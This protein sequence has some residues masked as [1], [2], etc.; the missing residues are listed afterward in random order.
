MNRL[1]ALWASLPHQVQAGFILFGTVA[2]TTLGKELQAL[3]FGTESFSRS[4]LQHDVGF[5]VA[6]GF[7]AVRAFYM[8]PSAPAEKANSLGAGK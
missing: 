7:I 8:V 3:I 1:K 5:A 2:L 6:A 4:T